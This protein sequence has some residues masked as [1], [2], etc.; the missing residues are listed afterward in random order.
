MLAFQRDHSLDG[1]DTPFGVVEVMY[2]EP[3]HWR[4]DA[5]Y[6]LVDERLTR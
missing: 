5:F 3:E 1:S 2:P 6:A 4:A